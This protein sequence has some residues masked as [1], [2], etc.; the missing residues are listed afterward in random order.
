MKDLDKRTDFE[1]QWERAFQNAEMV[2]NDAVWS[3]IDSTLSKQESGY[4][5]RKAFIFKMM[6]AASIAFAMGIGL[7]SLNHYIINGNTETISEIENT[8]SQNASNDQSSTTHL[9]DVQDDRINTGQ[10]EASAAGNDQYNSLEN[11]NQAST[12]SAHP[13]LSNRTIQDREQVSASDDARRTDIA[14]TTPTNSTADPLQ[15]DVTAP[16]SS[17]MVASLEQLAPLGIAVQATAPPTIEHIYRIPYMPKGASKQRNSTKQGRL[18]AS[19]DFGAGQFDPNF[20]AASGTDMLLSRPEYVFQDNGSSLSAVNTTDI[21]SAADQNTKPEISY[22][23]GANIGYRLSTRFLLQSGFTYRKSNTTTTTNGYVTNLD[24]SS[25]IPL[26]AYDPQL[27][28]FTTVMRGENITLNNQYEFASIPLRAGYVVI[29]RKLSLT[30]LAGVSSEIF[31]RN[32]IQDEAGF[33]ESLSS[34]DGGGSP[35]SSPY[36]NV[37]FN[38]SLA[39]MMGYTFAGNYM[40]TIEPSYRMAL[41]PFT[42]ESFYFSSYPSAFMLSF[43]IA[44]NFTWNP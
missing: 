15:K 29:D 11:Y 1:S 6:A 3:R 21:L 43:G 24:R 14:L 12:E 8:E 33:V 39:T 2:P 40:I 28:G 9:E 13:D 22:S 37:H 7:F 36:K 32:Q 44:Y 20:S 38:G 16:F 18:L 19:L 4:F 17:S 41:S 10:S 30:V 42:N 23:Y 34:E 26:A 5:K 27:E 25:K 31:M 35:Y